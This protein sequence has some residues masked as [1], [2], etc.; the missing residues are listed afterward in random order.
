MRTKLQMVHE[1]GSHL[2]MAGGSEKDQRGNIL[3]ELR[4]L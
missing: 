2:C 4:N 1:S 3:A